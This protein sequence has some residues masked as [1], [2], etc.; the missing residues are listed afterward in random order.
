MSAYEGEKAG[1]LSLQMD[2]YSDD[3]VRGK[4][5][6]LVQ[7]SWL[8]RDPDSNTMCVTIHGSCLRKVNKDEWCPPRYNVITK[9]AKGSLVVTLKEDN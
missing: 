2:M 9:G 6:T 8:Q 7:P 5:F 1:R 4:L 3:E